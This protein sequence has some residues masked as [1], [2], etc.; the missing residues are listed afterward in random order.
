MKKVALAALIVTAIAAP[1][2]ARSYDDLNAG[3]Q[4]F[5]LSQWDG[6]I[7]A[8]DKALAANDLVPNLQFIA[9][10]DRAWAHFYL[11]QYD[12]ALADYSASLALR[13]GESQVLIDRSMTYLNMGKL[14]EA[15]AGLDAVIAAHPLLARPYA[16]RATI[17][18]KRGQMDKS[19]EDM[20][21]LL[22]L[23]PEKTRRGN[24]VG[25]INWQ[26]GE[27]GD[28]E[29][30][31]SYEASHGP[32]TVYAWLWYSLAEVRLGKNVP[33][34]SLPDFDKKAWPA[35]IISFFLG[36]SAQDAV[37]AAARQGDAGA[38]KGQICE[39][40]FYVGEWLLQRHDP[41]AAKPLMAKAASDCPTNFIEW[42]PA[43]MDAAGLP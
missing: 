1:A 25:I 12:L 22:K 10:Y 35:P 37:F 21:T 4:L 17:N 23:L 41:G 24:G 14:E 43:Q 42:G 33:R 39:A 20:K 5:N 29:D 28:A 18:V 16:I 32:N 7:L 38:I 3:I 9:H 30:N 34:R 15:S 31:F 6:A 40:N 8:L 19:R 11:G 27:V 2:A 26:I 36:E 13:P